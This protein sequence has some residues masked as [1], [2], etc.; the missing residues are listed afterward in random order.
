MNTQQLATRWSYAS[1]GLCWLGQNSW[2]RFRK[3]GCHCW[4]AFQLLVLFNFFNDTVSKGICIIVLA[5]KLDKLHLWIHQVPESRWATSQC[6]W[7]G[8]SVYYQYH[9]QHGSKRINQKLLLGGN[10]D[11]EYNKSECVYFLSIIMMAHGS[12]IN[13]LEPSYTPCE[14]KRNNG[15]HL[16]TT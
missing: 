4:V 10:T 2:E 3:L 14:F 7:Q 12:R 1:V 9:L 16:S 8:I 6:F 5:V 11:G 13:K 15:I